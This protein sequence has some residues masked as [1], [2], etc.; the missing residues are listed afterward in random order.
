MLEN[1][2]T[3]GNLLFGNSFNPD[4]LCSIPHSMLLLL[5]AHQML[6]FE[7]GLLKWR[8]YRFVQLF[9]RQGQ[10]TLSLTKKVVH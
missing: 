7:E 4:L 10:C 3:L 1:T 8:G 2:S 6:G 5:Q 9:H